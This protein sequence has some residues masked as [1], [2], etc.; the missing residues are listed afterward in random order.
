M[1]LC[2]DTS[3]VDTAVAP[4]PPKKKTMANKGASSRYSELAN[5]SWLEHRVQASS[6]VCHI[7]V[8]HHQQNRVH[9]HTYNPLGMPFIGP[10]GKL[11]V[12]VGGLAVLSVHG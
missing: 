9:S 4:P 7:D 5:F 12:D 8:R 3:C 1:Q 2:V 11:L 10:F 6:Y